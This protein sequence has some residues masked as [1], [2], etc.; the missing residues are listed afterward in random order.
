MEVAETVAAA[1]EAASEVI[2]VVETID[3]TGYLVT[4]A[5]NT[6]LSAGFL[7]IING[8]L[9]FFL[10]VVLCYFAY[11]FFRIFF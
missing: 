9:V 6:A 8:I 7:Q 11:K 4:I 2:E 5:E 1:T 10:I 3:Y